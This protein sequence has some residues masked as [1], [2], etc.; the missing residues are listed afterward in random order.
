MIF[1]IPTF[2]AFRPR[3]IEFLAVE[4]PTRFSIFVLES[5][6]SSMPEKLSSVKV[7]MAVAAEKERVS[8]PLSP[9]SVDLEARKDGTVENVGLAILVKR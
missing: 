6:T 3:V 4:D 5:T 1:E 8:E 2:S 9:T 7:M